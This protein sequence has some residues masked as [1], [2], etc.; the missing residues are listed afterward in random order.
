MQLPLDLAALPISH[1][2]GAPEQIEAETLRQF[3]RRCAWSVLI[4][5]LEDHAFISMTWILVRRGVALHG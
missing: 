3:L 1:A 5:T 4:S 2:T